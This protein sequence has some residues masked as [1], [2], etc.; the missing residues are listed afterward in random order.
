[1]VVIQ[2]V[3]CP[4]CGRSFESSIDV[5]GGSQQYVE[6]CYV[7]CQPITFRTAVDHDGNL[8]TIEISREND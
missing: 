4:Y 8:L 6:D 5:S 1:M 2:I 3:Q 7:C